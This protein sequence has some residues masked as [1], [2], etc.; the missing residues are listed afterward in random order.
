MNEC[1]IMLAAPIFRLLLLT[2]AQA[3]PPPAPAPTE[4]LEP[5]AR[6]SSATC[7]ALDMLNDI[8]RGSDGVCGGSSGFGLN[9]PCSGTLSWT[10]ARDYCEGVGARLCTEFELRNNE[11]KGTGCDLDTALIWSSTRCGGNMSSFLVQTGSDNA[12]FVDDAC[13]A[14]MSESSLYAARCCADE[15]SCAPTPSPTRPPVLPPSPVPSAPTLFPTALPTLPP[16]PAPTSPEPALTCS[17][18]TCSQLG[19]SPK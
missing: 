18:K 17:E 13:A 9:K 1:I 16:S 8:E 6:C 15:H 11:A 2:L 12:P 3:S 19:V 14:E 10:E 5:V 4:L 7:S